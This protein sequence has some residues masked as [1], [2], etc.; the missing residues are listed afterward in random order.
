MTLGVVLADVAA[1]RLLDGL[2]LVLGW[3]AGGALFAALARHARSGLDR[4][5]ALAG[6]GGHLL[7]AL[8]H[9]LL[10]APLY[11][12]GD[13]SAN[14][15]GQ[16]ALA[17]VAAGAMVSGR[18]AAEGRTTLRV[19]LDATALAILAYESA[20]ALSG[21]TLTLALAAEAIAL[22]LVVRRNGSDP[23]AVA[24]AAAF[25]TLAAVHALTV[26]APPDALIHGVGD[27]LGAAAALL[28]AAVAVAAFA[29]SG[30]D[31][32]RAVAVARAVAAVLV[33]YAASA[34]VVTAL[35]PEQG[36]AALSALWAFTG[37][38]V[39]LAGLVRD[40]PLLRQGALALLAVTVTKVFLYDLAS[41]TS[42]YR[43]ASFIALGLLLLA[44]AFAWQR[45]RP[46]PLPDLRSMPDALR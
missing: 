17:V 36:Q 30:A 12:L 2:P 41:L 40:L 18:L 3:A 46:R 44:G 22:A 33:L 32:P 43:V 23:V 5:A 25:A 39:L 19:T 45:I 10:E 7:L 37:V 35:P 14:L 28:A 27:P 26:V 8:A 21:L 6:L 29:L 42:L 15:P 34:E 1:T 31:E 11:A 20:V 4:R 38:A 16:I 9:A 13:G 24:G